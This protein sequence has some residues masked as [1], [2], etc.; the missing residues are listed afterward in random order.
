[1]MVRVSSTMVWMAPGP[2]RGRRAEHGAGGAAEQEGIDQSAPVA[3]DT[4]LVL[5]RLQGALNPEAPHGPLP[6]QVAP[7]VKTAPVAAETLKPA[8]TRTCPG[9]PMVQGPCPGPGARPGGWWTRHP[10]RGP[11]PPGRRGRPAP[12][13]RPFPGPPQAGA[14][15]DLTSRWKAQKV[16]RR[17]P[18]GPPCC[19]GRRPG[20]VQAE[21]AA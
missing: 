4:P 20:P 9:S 13:P 12:G 7:S 6:K 15:R 21:A 2:A 16:Y 1:M 18:P 3:D 8:G 17:P 5:G 19:P 14:G 10:R 11:R